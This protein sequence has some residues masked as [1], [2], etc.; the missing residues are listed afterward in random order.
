M[1]GLQAEGLL[2]ED[3]ELVIHSKDRRCRPIRISATEAPHHRTR[4]HPRPGS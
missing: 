3:G 4:P 1:P 2:T